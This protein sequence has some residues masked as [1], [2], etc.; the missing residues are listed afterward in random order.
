MI[1]E[2][3][4]FNEKLKHLIFYGFLKNLII[5]QVNFHN[6]EKKPNFTRKTYGF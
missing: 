3:N 1:I 2:E 6:K 4:I 5:K